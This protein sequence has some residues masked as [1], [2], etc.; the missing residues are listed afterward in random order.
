MLFWENNVLGKIMFGIVTLCQIL[1]LSCNILYVFSI[2]YNLIICNYFQCYYFL[3]LWFWSNIVLWITI[4]ILMEFAIRNV[5]SRMNCSQLILKHKSIVHILIFLTFG[6]FSTVL[7]IIVLGDD[8]YKDET[9]FYQGGD[10]SFWAMFPIINLPIYYRLICK[11]SIKWNIAVKLYFKGLLA[12][13][14]LEERTNNKL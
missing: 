2:S 10:N 11:Y 8:L 13:R 6:L 1:W 12:L 7:L 9:E 3:S 4:H 5:W 14:L